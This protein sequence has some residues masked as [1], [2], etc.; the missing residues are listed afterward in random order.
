MA[1]LPSNSDFDYSSMYEDSQR[2]KEWK[3]RSFCDWINQHP[4]ESLTYWKEFP[5]IKSAQEFIQVAKHGWND[6]VRLD[7]TLVEAGVVAYSI[8]DKEPIYQVW[9]RLIA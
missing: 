3:D 6:T 1:N 8:N 2:T 5:T 7:W 9:M 4:G